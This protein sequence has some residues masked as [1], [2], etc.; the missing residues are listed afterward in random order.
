MYNWTKFYVEKAK[1]LLNYRNHQNDLVKILQQV[2][3]TTS[4]TDKDENG[5][6]PLEVMEPFSFFAYF[7][8]VGADRRSK[9]YK[10]FVQIVNFDLDAP[11]DY[12]GIPSALPVALRYF[13]REKDRGKNDISY[14]WNLAEEA[15]K[16]ELTDEAFMQVLRLKGIQIAKLTQGLFWLNPDKFYPIDIHK[17]Y[18]EKEGIDTKI[19]DLNDYKR[20]LVQIKDTFKKPYY[21]ISHEAWQ[22]TNRNDKSVQPPEQSVKISYIDIVKKIVKELKIFANDK[23]VAFTESGKNI[24]FIIGQRYCFVIE[25]KKPH[26]LYRVIS[27][28][29]INKTSS[30]FDG[31]PKAYLTYLD[32]L[33][34]VDDNFKRLLE[35]CR[36][37]LNR[38]NL[39]GFYRNDNKELRNLIFNNE[40]SMSK[41]K[42]QILF[43]PPGTGKTYYTVNYALSIIEN[44]NI[45][46]LEK[47]NRCVL[48]KLYENYVKQ[49]RIVFSTFHQSMCYEDFVEGIKPQKPDEDNSAINYK[50]ESGIFKEIAARAAYDCYKFYISERNIAYSFEELYESFVSDLQKKLDNSKSIIYKTKTNAET[51]VIR[52][53]SN[54]SVI[55]KTAYSNAKNIVSITK[56]NLQKIYDNYKTVDDIKSLSQLSDIDINTRQSKIFAVFQGL[57]IFEKEYSKNYKKSDDYSLDIDSLDVIK[58]HENGIFREAVIKYGKQANPFVLIIDE[59]NRG[60]VSQIFG[61]LITLIE[62]DKRL[63]A[64]EAIEVVLP[65]SKSK[66][67]VPPNLYIIGTMNTADRSVEALDTALRRRFSFIEMQPKIDLLDYKIDDIEVSKLLAKINERIEILLDSDHLVGHSYFLNLVDIDE[68]KLVFY[69]S[70]IPLLQ[71]YF[72][73]DFGKIGLILG[74]GFVSINKSNNSVFAEFQHDSKDEYIEK[75]VY[76]IKNVKEMENMDFKKALESLLAE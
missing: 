58:M 64:T 41:Y 34:Q 24:N 70:I 13:N 59:I 18:L 27:K 74:P 37:E 66:F 1:W 29:I 36:I 39:S 55:V 19:K 16:G 60:N 7:Q 21:Q 47:E 42:N 10:N 71:E 50:V 26:I 15:V 46:E 45:I 3:F 49:G 56:E 40:I 30:A 25:A 14:L 54:N 51:Q 61:E 52:I 62:D 2:G 76:T 22:W 72:Y 23:R 65:Y 20:V 73:G 6:K 43:G 68:L 38:T 9:F 33:S 69:K 63:G 5:V 44:R 57:K 8:S 32:T 31:T 53:S 48:K 67:S 17:P 75:P 35:Q 11:S 4:L 28:D 12:D